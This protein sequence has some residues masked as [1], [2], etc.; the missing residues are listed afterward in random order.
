MVLIHL[1]T[2]TD[3]DEPFLLQLYC[4]IR[5]DEFSSWP[6]PEEQKSFLMQMQYNMQ[7][8]QYDQQLSYRR[9]DVIWHDEQRIGRFIVDRQEDGWRI[10]DISILPSMQNQGIGSRLI[11]DL[12][13]E[14]KLQNKK[15]ALS[16]L[17]TNPAKSLYERL[18]FKEY[19][20]DEVYMG[21]EY[22]P[23]PD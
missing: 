8:Q 1:L 12:Q 9:Y 2:K 13:N 21:M 3:Q 6:M 19:R 4:N 5:A 17:L 20:R 14:A 11:T 18:G 10:I 16:V 23:S 22:T 7:K 15:V